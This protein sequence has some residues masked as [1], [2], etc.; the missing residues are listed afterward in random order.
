MSTL[1]DALLD[2][3][4]GKSFQTAE[5]QARPDELGVIKVSAVTWSHFQRKRTMRDSVEKSVH[6]AE[7]LNSQQ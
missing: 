1:A 7:S 5:I 6:I 4:S 2:I 3:Q